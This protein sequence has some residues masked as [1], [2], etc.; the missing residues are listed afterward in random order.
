KIK[1]K[2]EVKEVIYDSNMAKVSLVGAGMQ[3][4]PGVAA[5]MFTALGREG[6]NIDMIST[7]EIKISCAVK[8]GEGKRAVRVIHREFELDKEA[9]T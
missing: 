5:R 2:T 9:D 3:S 7:S 1:Q 4:H 6:I 8:K